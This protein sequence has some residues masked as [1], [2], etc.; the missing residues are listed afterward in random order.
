MIQI[1]IVLCTQKAAG[2]RKIYTIK[3]W[4][5]IKLIKVPCIVNDVV[6]FRSVCIVAMDLNLRNEIGL[7]LQRKQQYSYAFY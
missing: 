4:K 6:V 5:S 7:K 2:T 1:I 3:Y